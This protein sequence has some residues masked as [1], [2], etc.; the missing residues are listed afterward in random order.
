MNESEIKDK[1][2]MRCVNEYSRP[3]ILEISREECSPVKVEEYSADPRR[4]YLPLHY[5]YAGKGKITYRGQTRKVSA[6]DF[7]LVPPAEYIRYEADAQD[8]FC[9]Y[10]VVLAG[11]A[12]HQML[13]ALGLNADNV[14][15]SFKTADSGII[16]AFNTLLEYSLEYPSDDYGILG[17]FYL[18]YSVMQNR[19]RRSTERLDAARMHTLEIIRFVGRTYMN[20]E[21]T[22]AD[23]CKNLNLSASYVNRITKKEFGMSPKQYFTFTRIKHSCDW[24]AQTGY[25]FTKIARIVGY[26]DSRHFSREFKRAV[27]MTP[28]EYRSGYSRPTDAELYAQS[29]SD[30]HRIY[31]Q[32]KGD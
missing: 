6:G 9:Y 29:K 1:F 28:S 32:T 25:S 22:V 14:V 26:K 31:L 11:Q 16:Q 21:I 10:W 19:L 4:M 3:A 23:L 30:E 17:Y 27:G 18:L 13:D 24:I 8:P 12:A 2:F 20:P 7:F 5:I 15:A